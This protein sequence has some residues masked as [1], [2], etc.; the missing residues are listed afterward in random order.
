MFTLF[1]ARAV[2]TAA[3]CLL[4]SSCAA[5]DEGGGQATRVV[6]AF[7]PLQYVADRVAG[8]HADVSVLTAPGG[9]PHDLELGI[10]QIAEVE[11]ADVVVLSTGFQPAVDD[12]VKQ[13][14]ATAVVDATEVARLVPLAEDSAGDEDHH[15]T[16]HEGEHE[17]EGEHGHE[18]AERDLDPHFWLDPTRLGEVAAAVEEQLTAADPD[19]AEQFAANLADLESDLTAL[20]EETRAGLGD[21]ARSVLVVSHDA[22]G[23]WAD[24]YGLEV[25][26]INGLSPDAEP[27]PA[28]LR[29]LS[30]LI[31]SEGIT[32]VFS[33]TLASP[34]LA[35]TLAVE[36][37]IAT[38]V[39][40]PIE[41]LAESTSD[42]D[43][44]SLMRANLAV[45]Q[46]ANDCS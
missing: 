26:A 22:F 41:G 42:E 20:D 43:Y 33:E 6:T 46:K 21:C 16:G 30:D 13:S 36:L 29:E 39:L 28:H 9:E 4:L 18:A 14:G 45:V 23:Y 40:D 19:H 34:E 35:D 24:R 8:A 10:R 3:A 44:L 1:S 31:T 27:S 5:A 32:T 15:E 2:T 7:Y 25:E 38:A 37:G 11:E 12:A 17:A